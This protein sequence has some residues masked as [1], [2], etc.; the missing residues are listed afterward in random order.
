[1]GILGLIA[2]ALQAIPTTDLYFLNACRPYVRKLPFGFGHAPIE[3]AGANS[4]ICGRNAV[5][6]RRDA[7]AVVDAILR[8]PD[9]RLSYVIDDDL[10]VAERD[11]SLP[12]DYR[13]RLKAL[14]DGQH[15]ALVERAETIVVCSEHLARTY[16]A[17]GKAT[18]V[19]DPFWAE[20]LAGAEHF[21]RI[22]AGGPIDVAYLGSVTHGADRAFIFDVMA[23]LLARDPRVRMTLISSKP[24]GNAL[25]THPRVR[26]L[27][28]QPWW[29]YRQSL[30]RRRYH[31]ALYPMLDVPFNQ[32]RSLNKLIEHAV[33]G[34]PGIFSADWDYAHHVADGITG[35]LAENTVDAWVAATEKALGDVHSLHR[36]QLAARAYA[37]TLNDPRA[38]RRFWSDR[39]EFEAG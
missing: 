9:L 19:L 23:R 4:F 7:P 14:R 32:G 33:L 26:R 30:K 22:E 6:C 39:L 2:P 21:A 15:K 24:V 18:Q 31:L 27:R 16:D 20:P 17:M 5:V 25:D 3:R 1:M 13:D 12:P 28:P 11:S 34:A 10:A 35:M 8:D 37:Q 36:M 38:Q 29:L